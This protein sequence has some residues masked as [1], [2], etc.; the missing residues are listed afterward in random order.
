MDDFHDDQVP[1]FQDLEAA[2]NVPDLDMPDEDDEDD[3][4][5]TMKNRPRRYMQTSFKVTL[6]RSRSWATL[7]N[8]GRRRSDNRLSTVTKYNAL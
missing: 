6:K 7:L 3:E 1:D 2:Q 8:N 4:G 5:S